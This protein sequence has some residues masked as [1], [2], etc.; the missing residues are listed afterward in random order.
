MSRSLAGFV[1]RRGRDV[2]VRTFAE[3]AAD[4]DYGEPTWAPTDVTVKAVRDVP[5]VGQIFR[6]AGGYE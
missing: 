4:A 5:K 6:S 3:G 1:S 2:T